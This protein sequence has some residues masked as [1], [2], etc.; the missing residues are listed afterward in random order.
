MLET[1]AFVAN[2]AGS[3]FG[4]RSKK[5]RARRAHRR[6]VAEI[7][8]QGAN[9]RRDL[10]FSTIELESEILAQSNASGRRSG[11][12]GVAEI[13]DVEGVGG[14]KHG[15]R[16][17]LINQSEKNAIR[18]SAAGKK[19]AVSEANLQM[20]SNITKAGFDYASSL[21]GPSASSSSYNISP[22]NSPRDYMS[23]PGVNP[24]SKF[25][26]QSGIDFRTQS[27]YYAY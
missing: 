6:R 21:S 15:M 25:T 14:L 3:I 26:Y 9:A 23:S 27:P 4:G 19:A 11:D 24:G 7:R 18:E 17:E 8:R 22:R 1:V 16:R 20:F 13:R 12:A 10:L 2:V 5:R